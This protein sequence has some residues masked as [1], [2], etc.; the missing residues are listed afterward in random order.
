MGVGPGNT[1]RLAAEV[2]ENGMRPSVSFLFRSVVAMFGSNAA[3]VLLTGMGKDG[4]EE[5]KLLKDAGAITIAQDRET[6]VVFGMPNQAI[7]LDA[8]MY[9]LP[10]EGIAKTLATIVAKP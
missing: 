10:P 7:L 1:I 5:L 9:V 3:G 4:A 6:S 8:A 2:H